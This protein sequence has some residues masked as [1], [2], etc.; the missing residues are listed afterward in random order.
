MVQLRVLSGARAGEHV[1]CENFPFTIGRASDSDLV[2]QDAGIWD[3]HGKIA[4]SDEGVFQF[5]VSPDAFASINDRQAVEAVIR[6][7][8]MIELGAARL[9]F[10]FSETRQR[11]LRIRETFVWTGLAILAGTQVALI[12]VLLS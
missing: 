5:K 1:G 9:Q 6:N 8:D 11:S 4:L 12:W 3:R 7:G 2:L 10:W